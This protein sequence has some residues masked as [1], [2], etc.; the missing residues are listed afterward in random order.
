MQALGVQTLSAEPVDVGGWMAAG[1]PAFDPAPEPEVQD[2]TTAS[3]PNATTQ[4][5]LITTNL[6]GSTQLDRS[7]QPVWAPGPPHPQG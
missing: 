7:M 6:P 2:A 3:N 4:H 1:P 5:R